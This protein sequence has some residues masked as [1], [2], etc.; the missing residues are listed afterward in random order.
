MT[1]LQMKNLKIVFYLLL[2]LSPTAMASNWLTKDVFCGVSLD[3]NNMHAGRAE[4]DSNYVITPTSDTGNFRGFT[5]T[6]GKK[7]KYLGARLGYGYLPQ[8]LVNG[9]GCKGGTFS[10]YN[11]F[12]DGL[13][14]FAINDAFAIKGILGIGS[15]HSRFSGYYSD[16]YTSANVN[17]S[18]TQTHPRYGVGAEYSLTPN[19]TMDMSYVYQKTSMLYRDISTLSLGL[20]VKII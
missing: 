15:L 8:L 16:F 20:Q 12:A 7:F 4:T 6:I 5:V 2:I 11:I 13:G 17:F 19:V 3:S 10:A 14:F 9:Y 18:K 1:K